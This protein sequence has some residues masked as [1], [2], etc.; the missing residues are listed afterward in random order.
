MG[1]A[2]VSS[3]AVVSTT[4]DPGTDT[5]S[6]PG[7]D[8]ESDPGTDT[9]SDPGTDTEDAGRP[10]PAE[11]DGSGPVGPIIPGP[12]EG[13]A[14]SRDPDPMDAERTPVPDGGADRLPALQAAV[15]RVE[16]RLAAD[17]ERAAARERVIDRQHE[18]IERLR[19]AQRAGQSRPTVVDLYRLRNDLLR[20]AAAV[21]ADM[22]GTEVAALL[23][24]YAD[25]VEEALER[26]G[27]TVMPRSVGAPFE[28]GRH[29]VASVAATRDPKLDGTVAA[30]VQDGYVD[31][32]DAVV[33]P[34]RITLHRYVEEETADE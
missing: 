30:V 27:T 17:A 29:R 34:A 10:A 19:S 22:T 9:A 16:A 12:A 15:D 5:E 11:L 31:L 28:A 7:T 33:A 13:L 2:V 14:D 4:S 26:C 21:P 20:Q 6:D 32:D 3:T 23:S 8:T 25:T 24:S 18:E 1:G